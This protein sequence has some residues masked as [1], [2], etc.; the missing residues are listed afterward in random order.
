MD[1][2][3]AEIAEKVFQSISD[4]SFL[5]GYFDSVNQQIV[6]AYEN[7][8][9]TYLDTYVPEVFLNPQADA[10]YKDAVFNVLKAR[11]PKIEGT[12]AI[13]YQT[14]VSDKWLAENVDEAIATVEQEGKETYADPRTFNVVYV[15]PDGSDVAQGFDTYE[16]AVSFLE[17]V[18]TRLD[19]T[20]EE[21]NK[22]L[23]TQKQ[24]LFAGGQDGVT[25]TRLYYTQGEYG[26]QAYSNW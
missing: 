15:N 13:D 16:A 23:T 3:K 21:R 5:Q 4:N 19:K 24:H 1:S 17:G 10:A 2:I 11:A 26:E 12:D 25:G 22:W 18:S 20:E 8:V 9:I 14:F 6:T 7:G